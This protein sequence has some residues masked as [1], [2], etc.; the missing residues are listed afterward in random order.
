[1]PAVSWGLSMMV[2]GITVFLT[3][4]RSGLL[5][6]LDLIIKMRGKE[7]SKEEWSVC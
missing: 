6:E 3:S 2:M 1:M 5:I 4:L 7:A